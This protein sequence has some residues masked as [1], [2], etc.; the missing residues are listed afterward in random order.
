[1]KNQNPKTVISPKLDE[2]VKV[3]SSSGK[4]TM[5]SKDAIAA[6]LA[7]A[8]LEEVYEAAARLKL[9]TEDEL[10]AKYSHLNPG[11]QRMNLGNRIRGAVRKMDETEGK[12]GSGTNLLEKIAANIVKN[13]AARAKAADALTVKVADIP[14]AKVEAPAKAPSKAKAK[15]VVDEKPAKVKKRA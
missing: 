8:T 14:K 2:Y 12:E 3:R 6:A 9:G 13:I 15:A 10:R 5:A 1:M 11:Q 7:G 4:M